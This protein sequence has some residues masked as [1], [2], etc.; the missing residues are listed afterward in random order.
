VKKKYE[1]AG[2]RIVRDARWALKDPSSTPASRDEIFERVVAKVAQW[3]IKNKGF[4]KVM[5]VSQE[6]FKKQLKT[7]CWVRHEC[8]WDRLLDILIRRGVFAENGG[9][10]DYP[11]V[12]PKNLSLLDLLALQPGDEAEPVKYA[13]DGMELVEGAGD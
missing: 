5:G 1:G 12:S 9:A 2:L 11:P 3:A 10:L 7:I 8:K 13:L 6:N 4:R